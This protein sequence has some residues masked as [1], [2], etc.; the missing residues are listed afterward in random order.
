MSEIPLGDITVSCPQCGGTQFIQSAQ[1]DPE[2]NVHECVGCG[3]TYAGD[4]LADKFMATDA[5]NAAVE[6]KVGNAIDELMAKL[7]R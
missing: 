5:A 1:A 4:D 2:T 3:A 6:E 7:L